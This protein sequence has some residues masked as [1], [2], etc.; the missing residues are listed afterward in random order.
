VPSAE[1]GGDI[2]EADHVRSTFAYAFA[3]RLQK[4]VPFWADGN[5]YARAPLWMPPG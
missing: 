1:D 3:G 4:R 2:D 5:A